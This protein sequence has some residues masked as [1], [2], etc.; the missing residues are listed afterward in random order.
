MMACRTGGSG[1]VKRFCS[2]DDPLYKALVQR[3]KSDTKRSLKAWRWWME[4]FAPIPTDHIRFEISMAF[5]L[6][7]A[8]YRTG[9]RHYVRC[10]KFLG[11]LPDFSA[12]LA[13]IRSYDKLR[14]YMG[15]KGANL[16]FFLF[17]PSCI[18][19]HDY[20]SL[21]SPYRGRCRTKYIAHTAID[22]VQVRSKGFCTFK[23]L[24]AE[25][26]DNTMFSETQFVYYDNQRA[27]L[28]PKEQVC[29]GL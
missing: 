11:L 17:Y 20:L 5:E 7:Y 18:S 10:R 4:G 21:L 15:A 26:T 13:F 19:G 6:I 22:L 23:G 27:D 14:I 8:R 2:T 24:V 3:L 28:F 16:P 29:A 9:D 1:A 25:L 12:L